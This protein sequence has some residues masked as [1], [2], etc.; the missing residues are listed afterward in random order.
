MGA[1]MLTATIAFPAES[2]EPPNFDRGRQLLEEITDASLF[3]FDEPEAELEKLLPDLDGESDL[4]DENGK[5]LIE[6]AR[7]AG[8]VIIDN[9]EGALDSRETTFLTV[10]DYRIYISGGLSS[11]DS[12]TEAAEAIW[13][14]LQAARERAPRHGFHPGLRAAALPR[15]QPRGQH[16][17][18]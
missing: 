8:L 12:P 6:Y 17:P 15:E 4:V 9:L 10:A 5:V 14:R 3:T 11:G 18:H 1:S 2:T 16:A 13:G 7:R